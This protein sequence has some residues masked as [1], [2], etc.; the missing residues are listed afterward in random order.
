[1]PPPV[2]QPSHV[3]VAVVGAGFAGIGTAA[4]LR[5]RGTDDV[6]VFERAEAIGGV[7]RD[8]VYPGAACDV[9]SHLYHL[10]DAPHS[11]WSR[12]F[13]Q[14]PEI[15]EYLE[16]VVQEK[17]LARHIALGTTVEQAVW[18]DD[19]A[20]W[21][22]ET[23]KG[24]WTA[25][26]LVGAVGALAEP[27][28]P[29]IPGLGSF[30][31]PVLHTARWD[32]DLELGD[33]RV[34]VVGTGASA[35]QLVPAIQPAVERLTVFMRTPP[36]LIPRRDRALSDRARQ[37]LGRSWL[38]RGLR[39]ALYAAHEVQGVPFRNP[40][41]APLS[42]LLARRHLHAQVQDPALRER[43]T[44]GYRFG[45][46]R[47]LLSD[48]FYPAI[49]QPNVTLAGAAATVRPD[50]VVEAD[51]TAHPTD[52]LVFATGF[53]VHDF[54]FIDRITGRVGRLSEVWQGEPKAHVGTTVAGFPN[55]FVMQGPNTGLGHSS[56]LMMM[57]AQIEHL[58]NALDAMDRYGLASVEPRPQA[59]DAFV[60]E[61]DALSEGTAWTSGCDSWYLGASGRNAAI[62]PGSVGAFRRRV[63]PFDPSDYVCRSARTAPEPVLT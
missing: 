3:R 26:V 1:M 22:I 25:D 50:A 24:G 40:K 63:A 54:P 6:V 51:G 7:W 42:A 36:T 39:R 49:Q 61:V 38:R 30:A 4:R 43:L 45:C 56:V 55:L 21:R 10:R 41:V 15:H 44:P 17:D 53:H 19:A 14:Q 52:V 34:A 18:D 2:P 20:H 5:A 59:Q 31:G 46:K 47:I 16:R 23:D 12:W 9:E 62:W 37:R 58:V 28:F 32:T 33:K 27:R 8:N 35:I 11:D 48:D 29:D 57:E 13:A 60:A